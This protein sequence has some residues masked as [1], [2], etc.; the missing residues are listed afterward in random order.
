MFLN[1]RELAQGMLDALAGAKTE[2]HEFHHQTSE[3][4]IWVVATHLSRVYLGG[5]NGGKPH[6]QMDDLG[7]PLFLDTHLGGGFRYFWNV[8][9]YLGNDPI[10]LAHIFQM[11]W[12][13]HQ[14]VMI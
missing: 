6:E 5:E 4:F 10:W 1:L 12:F 3:V 7:V 8:Q 9:P 13:N 11:G 14:L 2:T